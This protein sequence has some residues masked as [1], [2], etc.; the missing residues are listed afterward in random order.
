MARTLIVVRRILE[1]S[2]AFCAD[3]R[4]QLS[5]AKFRA[6]MLASNVERTASRLF[7]LLDAVAAVEIRGGPMVVN[8]RAGAIVEVRGSGE[9]AVWHPRGKKRSEP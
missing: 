9:K 1:E 8:V 3:R 7:W 2:K 5:V 6:W 4:L